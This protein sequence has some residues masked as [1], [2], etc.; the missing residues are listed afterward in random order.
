MPAPRTLRL[1]LGDQ[2]NDAHSWFGKHDDTVLY[3]LMEIRQET[4]YVKHHVQKILAFFA[5]MRA[6]AKMLEKR[7]HRVV[8]LHL[9]DPD[10]LQDLP[11]NL[12]RLIDKHRIKRF[13]YQWPDEYRLDEQLNHF[14]AD[15]EIDAQGC[16]TEHFLTTRDTLEKM[17]AGKKRFLMETFYREMRKRHDILLDG[18]KP[19]G[20]KWNYDARNRRRYDGA[21]PIPTP[22]AF[23]NDVSDILKMLRDQKVKTIGNTTGKRLIWPVTRR[24]ANGQLTYFLENGL[25]HFGTYQDALTTQGWSLFHSRLSFALNVKLLDPMKVVQAAVD[26]WQAAQETI[27][28]AQVE[29][30]VRQVL[31]WREYMRGIYWTLMPD[32]GGMNVLDHDADLPDCYWTGDTH[33]QCMAH[34]IGQ[35]LDYAYAHHIQRL[36]VTGNFALLAGVHPDAVEAWYLGV[37]VDAIQWVEMPNTRGMSQFADGGI[38]ATKPYVSSAN[39]IHKMS[40]YC[41]DCTYAHNLRHGE[42]A[43]PFNSLYWHFLDRHRDRLSANH[44]M[45]TMYRVLDRMDGDEKKKVLRQGDAYLKTIEAL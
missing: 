21:V 16:D 36:M 7:G 28:I 2:L 1:I 17:F 6:F 9:D 39:Y 41:P 10:N 31:G 19:V 23:K 4:D 40:D 37:Y 5:A 20:G 8:Y 12:K 13:E 11:A 25:P 24:Q 27:S 18:A 29:G 32:F 35:S 22:K 44:R 33:M 26:R 34:A 43:C 14:V 45:G 30:F 15:L 42:N 3:V 38:I